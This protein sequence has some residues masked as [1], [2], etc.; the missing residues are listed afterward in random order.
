MS[1][2]D[3][4]LDTN[5]LI[6]AH[7]VDAGE[8]HTKAAQLVRKFWDRPEIPAVSIQVLQEMH[9]NLVRKGVPLE[10]SAGTVCSYLACHR[11]HPAAAATSVGA[12]A[13]TAA[14]LLGCGGSRRRSA[15]RRP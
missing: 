11:E 8:K 10:D 15:S 12:A 2:V 1:A 4:F 9:V 6:Y 5:I 3:I 14:F 7:D 13:A